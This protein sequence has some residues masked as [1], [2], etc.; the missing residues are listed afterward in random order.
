MPVKL[1][2]N[3]DPS[4]LVPGYLFPTISKKVSE[5]GEKNPDKKKD[6]I[7]MG[8]GD[9]Q[10]IP[11][12]CVEAGQKALGEQLESGGFKGYGPEQ[13]YEW[14]RIAIAR[15]YS[16]RGVAIDA[17]E[18]F[19]SN[20]AK[21]DCGNFG[22]I[23][24]ADNVVAIQNPVYPVYNDTNIMAGRKIVKM[25]C[26]AENGFFP[27]MPKERVDIV[28]LCFPNNPTGVVATKAQLKKVVDWANENKVLILFD[29]AYESFI[30]SSDIPHSIYEI[31]G[32]KSCAVEFCSLSKTAGFTGTRCAW[33]IVPKD[34][35]VAEDVGG[36]TL[37]KM[38]LRRQTTK[39]N[40]VPYFV[41]RMAEAYFTKEGREEGA[42]IRAIYQSN[43][44]IIRAAL[45]DAGYVV[46]GGVDS[47]YVWAEVPNGMP[48]WDYFDLAL[49]AA[50]VVVTPGAGFGECGEGFVRFS[51]FNYEGVAEVAMKRILSIN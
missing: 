42:R 47:P 28:Y 23:L 29:A 16:E 48:S 2:R 8:I 40:S 38:W 34:I 24:G 25:P 49:N 32:A 18:V 50:N 6:L 44:K 41:Q 14:L 5:W 36:L 12:V 4:V 1:N 17:D 21:E 46:H 27:E 13:G 37:N 19:V 35:S 45:V 43:A 33:T 9:A 30:Q 7:R 3:Y 26:V 39:F 20:G 51:A 15:Y 22:D 31:E 11:K 10:Y